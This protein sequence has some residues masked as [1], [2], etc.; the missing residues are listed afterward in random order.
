MIFIDSRYFVIVSKIEHPIRIRKNKRN[1]NLSS[2][3]FIG[4][5]TGTHCL[6]EIKHTDASNITSVNQLNCLI[7]A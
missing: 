6:A 5:A 7:S 4:S 2:I 1:I 3:F